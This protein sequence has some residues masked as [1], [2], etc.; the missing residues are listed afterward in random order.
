MAEISHCCDAEEQYR[1]MKVKTQN[2]K[3]N[4]AWLNDHV[5]GTYVKLAQKEGYR[6]GTAY[7]LKEIDEQLGLIKPGYTVVDLGSTPGA[8]SQY[9]QQAPVTL[10]CCSGAAQRSNHCLGHLAHG[11]D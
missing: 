6:A 7:K 5:D 4:K 3:V 10:G 2:K 1:H 11:G 8:W 9:L